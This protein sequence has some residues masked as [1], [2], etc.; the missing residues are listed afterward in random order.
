MRHEAAELSEKGVEPKETQRVKNLRRTSLALESEAPFY[1][2]GQIADDLEYFGTPRPA[3]ERMAAVNAVN[4][5][6]IRK[7]FQRFPIT[8][9]G[10]LVSVGPR[11]WPG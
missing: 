11:Q 10:F 8:G 2:L 6:T 1:R 7:Y 9:E 3:E 5:E 4:D